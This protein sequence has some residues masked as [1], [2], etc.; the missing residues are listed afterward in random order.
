MTR[1][2]EVKTRWLAIVLGLA[3]CLALPHPLLAQC[4]NNCTGHG[5]CVPSQKNKRFECECY[6]GWT[7]SACSQRES[8]A[9][10][11]KRESEVIVDIPEEEMEY[12]SERR[13]KPLSGVRDFED[14]AQSSWSDL[15]PREE[16]LLKDLGWRKDTWNAKN[17]GRTQWPPSMYMPFDALKKKEQSAVLGLGFT[18]KD[19]NNGEQVSMIT[20]H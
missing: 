14:V 3:A 7:G 4:P 5:T 12:D 6:E 16:V 11:A 13:G 10:K 2:I 19:W 20:H 15:Q 1:S 9:A 17:S 8:A 18:P